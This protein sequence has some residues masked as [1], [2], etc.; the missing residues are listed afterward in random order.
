MKRSIMLSGI[1]LFGTLFFSSCTKNLK[2]DIRDLQKKIDDISHSL[3]NDEPITPVTI[4]KDKKGKTI[5]IADA[6]KFKANDYSTQS[7]IKRQDGTYDVN[8]ERFVDVDWTDHVIISFKYDPSTKA[9][10]Q[11]YCGHYWYDNGDYIGR[12]VYNYDSYNKGLSFDINLKKIDLSTGAIS[13][14][15]KI[16]GT[17]EYSSGIGPSYVPWT[18]TAL[19]TSFSFDGKLRVY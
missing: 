18:G 9:I 5:T 1:M 8:I 17:E 16:N 2:D 13:F 11:K 12:A 19:S 7:L 6:Y 3:G 10:T 14:D 15:V 4:F